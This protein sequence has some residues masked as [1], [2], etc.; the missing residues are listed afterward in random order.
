MDAGVPTYNYAETPVDYID[1]VAQIAE[2]R[3]GCLRSHGHRP[4]H[5]MPSAINSQNIL[6]SLLLIPATRLTE[7]Q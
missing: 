6:D 3:N 7:V 1:R 5:Q 2:A 4:E